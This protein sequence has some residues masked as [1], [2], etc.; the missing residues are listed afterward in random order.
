MN[1]QQILTA[2]MTCIVVDKNTVHAKPY[3]IWE[4]LQNT[5]LKSRRGKGP[6]VYASKLRLR[7]PVFVL[8]SRVS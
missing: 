7:V 4:Q 3:S 2:V 1:S 6:R 5:P 8:F